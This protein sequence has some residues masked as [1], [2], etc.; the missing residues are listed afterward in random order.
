[1]ILVVILIAVAAVILIAAAV[2]VLIVV[3]VIV[4]VRILVVVLISVL[5]IHNLYP[6]IFSGGCSR[7][8]SLPG[9]SGFI[10]WLK[11]KTGK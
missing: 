1:M 11:K 6:P 5:V 4:L 10:L 7:C 9:I 8:N 2:G 3:L